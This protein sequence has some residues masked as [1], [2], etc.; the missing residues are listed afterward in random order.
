MMMQ[1]LARAMNTEP[2][3]QEDESNH[4]VKPEPHPWNSVQ[5]TKAER[6][7]KTY[8]QIQE[9]RKEKWEKQDEIS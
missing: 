2:S 1:A 9:L 4:A 7:G 8:E 6:K 3:T 5:L